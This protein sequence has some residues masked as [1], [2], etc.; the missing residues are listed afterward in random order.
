MKQKINLETLLESII[1]F[2]L[3]ALL[4]YALISDKVANYVHP[5]INGYLWF[6]AIALLIISS[7]FLP[8]AF[9]PK[10]N[11]KPG[12]YFLYF[13]PIL[14]VILIPAGT[15][16]NKAISFGSTSAVGTATASAGTSPQNNGAITPVNPS[17]NSSRNSTTSSALFLPKEDSDG[18]ITIQDEQ[19]ANWY[20][21]IN[22]NMNQYDGKILKFKGQVFRTKDFAKN[23]MIPVRY[24]MVC[25]T[26][27][28]QPCG[29]LCR[30][31]EVTQYQDNEWVWVTGKIKIEKYKV[32]TMPI[33]YVTKIEK[34]EKANNDYIY[35]TYY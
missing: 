1:C 3:S 23:E 21:D 6:A 24:A 25:C 31:N 27:D 30:G 18:I 33:C 29:I 10:H 17:S 15:V 32:Q 5:R 2:L 11:A 34:A 26:A 13:V 28:L 4:F 22:Q 7:M 16:Q 12:K 19:F 20:Q 14:F 8:S 9:T 35:F